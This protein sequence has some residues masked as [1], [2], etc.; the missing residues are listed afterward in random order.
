MLL[1]VTRE[2]CRVV[3][4]S[5]AEM[6]TKKATKQ[7]ARQYVIV[8]CDKAGVHCG[9]LEK[10]TR[11]HL[12]LTQSRRVWYWNG[13]ASISEIAVHGLNPAKSASCKI[14]AE[15]SRIQL[16]QSDVCEVIEMHDAGR[17]SIQ[18]MPVWRA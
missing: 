15:V 5:E 18:G 6:A 2:V 16:R 13:A 3:S 8:R 4:E 9:F 1:R 10:Q 7:H 17:E 12:V 14:A 11:D